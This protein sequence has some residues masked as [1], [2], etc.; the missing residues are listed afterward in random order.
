MLKEYIV[1]KFMLTLRG[2]TITQD[3]KGIEICENK[4]NLRTLHSINT[5]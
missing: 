1:F 5:K 4:R 3:Y 2:F